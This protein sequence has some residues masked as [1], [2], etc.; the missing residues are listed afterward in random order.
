[1][2]LPDATTLY[3]FGYVFGGWNTQADGLG[4]TY[5]PGASFVTGNAAQTLYAVWTPGDADY[6]IDYYKVRG[7]GT[8]EFYDSTV[9]TATTGETVTVTD[10]QREPQRPDG[11]SLRCLDRGWWHSLHERYFRC[12]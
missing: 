6:F 12:R 3:R 1:M 2:T 9:F 4:T 11:L 10:D 7:D 8:I 5:A